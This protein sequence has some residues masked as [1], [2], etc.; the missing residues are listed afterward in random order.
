MADIA[1]SRV[2]LVTGTDTG[3]GKTVATAAVAAK[4]ISQ[5]LRSHVYKPVQT[6][7][8]CA[9]DPQRATLQRGNP[10]MVVEDDAEIAG[11]LAGCS[12]S[13]GASYPLPAAPRAAAAKAQMPL[14]ALQ[15]HVKRIE[16]L[17]LD[18]DVVVVEGAGGLLV[19]LGEYTLADLAVEL[20]AHLGPLIHIVVVVRPNL[21]T[22]NHTALTVEALR[23]RRLSRFSVVIGAWPEGPTEVEISNREELR[24]TYP[25]LGVVPHRS[26]T[27]SP[28]TFRT[29]APKW[30]TRID[31]LVSAGQGSAS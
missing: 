16:E 14:P 31:S 20:Q 17:L 7:L 24:R 1:A 18:H 12:Y 6:G 27:L 9:G 2:I 10:D 15:T 29:R 5:G 13:T 4:L 22:L 8:I 25:L 3:V 19:D 23:Y 30:L 21:G 11:K 28:E 26:G